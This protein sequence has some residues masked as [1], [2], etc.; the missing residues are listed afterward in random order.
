MEMFH[1]MR[2]YIYLIMILQRMYSWIQQGR[3][4]CDLLDCEHPWRVPDVCGPGPVVAL[5]LREFHTSFFDYL[6][7]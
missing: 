2:L 1:L 7:I 4:C 3:V 5:C 6:V